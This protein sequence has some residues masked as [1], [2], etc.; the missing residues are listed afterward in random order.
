MNSSPVAKSFSFHS[1]RIF[2][3]SDDWFHIGT[4]FNDSR[5]WRSESSGTPP[6]HDLQ[7]FDRSSAVR[8]VMRSS[9][10]LNELNYP[11][12]EFM[13]PDGSRLRRG[14]LVQLPGACRFLCARAPF[15]R[16]RMSHSRAGRFT[17][18]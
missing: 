2:L 7:C 4:A 1:R 15:C 14:F 13:S 16:S 9:V 17:T 11:E 6:S 5:T 12:K 3:P 8:L 18:D 10:E